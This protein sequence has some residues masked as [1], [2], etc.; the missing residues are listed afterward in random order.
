MCCLVRGPGAYGLD[1]R[2]GIQSEFAVRRFIKGCLD[3]CT[4]RDIRLMKLE[5]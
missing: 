2:I 1:Q 4:G 5:P 3:L